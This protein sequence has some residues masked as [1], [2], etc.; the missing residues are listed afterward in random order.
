MGAKYLQE[1]FAGL[2]TGEWMLRREV[3]NDWSSESIKESYYL[4]EY[5]YEV[6]C[7]TRNGKTVRS[8]GT[9]D[10]WAKSHSDAMLGKIIV[11]T[12]C[13]IDDWA[14]GKIIVSINV[15]YPIE[16][17]DMHKQWQARLL[18]VQV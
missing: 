16:R 10:D 4:I 18:W 5:I 13:T 9:K 12:I 2:G 8:V 7:M 3:M 11:N 1:S 17:N 15:W 14:K 6:G